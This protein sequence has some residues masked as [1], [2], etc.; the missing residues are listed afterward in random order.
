MSAGKTWDAAED[1]CQT[2]DSHLASVP[3][4]TVREYILSSMKKKNIPRIW[5]GGNDKDYE[6]LWVWTDCSF[7]GFTSWASGEP[8]NVGNE[9]CIE[10]W[11]DW[12]KSLRGEGMWNDVPCSYYKHPF[13][14]S[15]KICS[16]DSFF[17]K[18]HIHIHN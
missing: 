2:Q 6:G 11:K 10:M 7:F 16:G 17:Y 5:L 13:L 12:T 3:S 18:L 1:F 14:C 9:D 4:S 8:N 15:K